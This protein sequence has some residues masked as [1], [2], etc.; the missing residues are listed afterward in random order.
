MTD[1]VTDKQDAET[2]DNHHEED[3]KGDEEIVEKIGKKSK[4]G[5]SNHFRS[6]SMLSLMS[7]ATG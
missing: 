3:Q 5:T 2:K 1:N 4:K 7:T 6:G